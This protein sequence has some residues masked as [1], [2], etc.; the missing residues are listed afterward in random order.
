MS[1]KLFAV[2]VYPPGDSFNRVVITSLEAPEADVLESAVVYAE[3]AIAALRK[4]PSDQWRARIV[5][6]AE[7]QDA[8]I[9]PQP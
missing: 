7:V 1:Q 3:Q 2:A 4:V 9:K 5:A 6:G 8:P